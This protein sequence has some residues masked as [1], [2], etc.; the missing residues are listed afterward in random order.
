MKIHR[1][2]TCSGTTPG[3]VLAK[4]KDP[5]EEDQEDALTRIGMKKRN[6]E[7][8]EFNLNDQAG[9]GLEFLAC[10]EK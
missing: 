2:P 4:W 1:R 10:S 5:E 8:Y 3:L 9:N 7:E 6:S